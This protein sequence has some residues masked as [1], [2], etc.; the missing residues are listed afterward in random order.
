VA[1]RRPG[2]IALRRFGDLRGCLDPDLAH[3]PD[4]GHVRLGEVT[5]ERPV[6]LRTLHE[7]DQSDLR[8]LIA[9]PGQRLQLGDHA[10][11]C[12]QDGDGVDLA[13][14]VKHLR[15]ADLL[16]QNSCDCHNPILPIMPPLA[17]AL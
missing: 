3:Q 14:L 9:V 17:A 16:A 5:C 10:R 1:A 7:L 2:S 4:R 13:P 6:D 15:H 8:G 11:A 12:L